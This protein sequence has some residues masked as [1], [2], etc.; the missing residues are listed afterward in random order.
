MKARLVLFVLFISSISLF[1]QVQSLVR[2]GMN[3]AYNFQFES[4]EKTFNR[5]LE[6]K[7]NSPEGYYRISQ[8][9]F[10]IFLGSRDEGEYQ[11]F[12]KFAD[13]AQEKIDA[14]LDKNPKDLNTKYLA[15]NLASFRAMAQATS[16]QSVDAFWYSKKAVSQFEEIIKANPKYYDA[17]LGV[18]L[19]D[20]AM[21]FVPD[22]LKWAVN[23]T[24]LSS[25][26]ERGFRYIKTALR[27]GNNVK[28]EA[29]FHL[30]KIYNDYLA[31]YDSGYVILQDLTAKY[32]RNG[33][34]A[35]QSAVSL[36]KAKKL[37]RAL[38]VLDRVIQLNNKHVPQITAL[39]YYRR[40]EIYFKKNQ[41]RTAIRNYT[42][43]LELTKELDFIGIAALNTALAYKMLGDEAEY[44]TYLDMAGNGNL[45]LFEDTYAMQKKEQYQNQV[46]SN[47]ELKLVRMRNRIYSGNYKTVYDS[48]NVE[49]PK[50]DNKDT[51]ALA[52]IYLAKA[53]SNLKKHEEVEELCN[54]LAEV[55][56]SS[57]KWIKPMASLLNA[58]AKFALGDKTSAKELLLDAE[59]ENDYDFRDYIQ[60][61]IEW[62]KRRVK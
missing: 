33:L 52:Q 56:L 12:L 37:D 58:K 57:D 4:A 55:S 45:D 47:T 48:L 38:T 30:S 13:L 34:F 15:A 8:M 6:I 1:A 21:S 62:L 24:G 18:G 22:F 25:D 42:K 5:I 50:I 44:K 9:H 20:Y 36:I 43:F 40:G 53:A 31:E 54:Q 41:F 16:N 19:F 35:Y 32:P 28:T 7:P 39:A 23:L 27:K 29:A 3:E 10:W 2:K 60:S 46:I 26:K 59:E 51:K 61:Q 14:V 11:T 49:L 17:Y